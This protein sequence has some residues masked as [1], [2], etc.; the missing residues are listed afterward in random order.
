MNRNGTAL[1]LLIFLTA[2]AAAQGVTA[3]VAPRIEAGTTLAAARTAVQK[4]AGTESFG[5]YLETYALAL[6]LH[7]AVALC[8][9]YLPRAQ[10]ALRANLASFSGSL[11]LI[12]GRYD[13]AGILFSQGTASRP[14]LLLKAVRCHLAAG[15]AA[16]A[17][18]QLDLVPETLDGKSYS[19]EKQI[20]LSWLLM[21]EGEAEKAFMLLRPLVPDNSGLRREILFLLWLV[22]SSPEFADFK[23]ATKG[24]DA[25]SIETRIEAEH[26]GSMELSLI[27][28]GVARKPAAWLLTGLYASSGEP[29]TDRSLAQPSHSLN[30]PM[31]SGASQAK[32][33]VG[34]FSRKE[35]AAA[36]AAKLVTKGFLA[37]TDEQK[38][39]DGELRWAVVVETGGDWSKTQAK[40]KDLGY[41]SYLLP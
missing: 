8:R 19:T 32:L 26:A 39:Q 22:A 28:K 35:N 4:M 30:Q 1:C 15:N 11:A 34:W 25:G 16:E 27:R 9:E 29:G 37:K 17:K 2:A 21:L 41:E 36:L 23:V 18:K 12:A 13:D 5:V 14:D 38:T 24:Y 3:P 33:Q 40:L 20:A 31:E 10:P 6:P 7:D